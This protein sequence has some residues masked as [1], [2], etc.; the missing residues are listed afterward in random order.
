MSTLT[1]KLAQI[2]NQAP[3]KIAVQIKKGA[4]YVQYTYKEF[5]DHVQ[6][7]AC[8][9]MHLEIKQGDKIIIML[10][11]RPEWG[12]IYFG[13]LMAGAIAVPVDPQSN[14]N[15]LEYFIKDSASKI[16]F[17]S[18][19]LLSALKDV[20]TSM[21]AKI[22]VL[23]EM[24]KDVN[25]KTLPFAKF[26]TCPKINTVWPKIQSNHLASI[27]YTSGTTGKPKGVQLTHA[28]FYANFSS[29]EKLKFLSTMPIAPQNAKF[30]TN[31][32]VPEGDILSKEY[33]EYC[34]LKISSSGAKAEV[35]NR[36]LRCDGHRHNVLSILPLHHSFPFMVTL[37][38]PLFTQNKITYLISLKREEILTCMREAG[39]TVL[40]GVPQF[41]VLLSKAINQAIKTTPFFLRWPLYGLIEIGWLLRK[42]S[43]INLNKYFLYK[44]HKLFGKKL[45]FLVCGG[46]KLNLDVEIFFNKLGFSLMQGYGLTETAPVVTFNPGVLRKLGSVGK[47]IPDVEVK[48]INQDSYGIG[49]IIIKGA[50]VMQGYYNKPEETAQVIKNGW[51]YSGDLGYLDPDGFL[52]IT[53][54]KKELI[55]LSSGKNITPEQVET[56]YQQSLFIK[57]LC[58]VASSEDKIMAV[59]VP[60]FDHLRKVGVIDAYTMIK[61]DLEILSK[62][63]PEYKRIMGF[64]ITKEDLPRTRLGKLKRHVIQAEYADE[65]KQGKQTAYQEQ[66]VSTDDLQII[67]TPVFKQIVEV[68]QQEKQVQQPISL[69]DHLGIDLGFDSLNRVELIA[70]LEKKFNLRITES[71]MANVF[72]VKELVAAVNDLLKQQKPG[73]KPVEIKA[74]ETLWRDLLNTDPEKNITDKINL[75]P[76]ILDK[77]ATVMFCGGLKMIAKLAW[78]IEVEGAEN[79]PKDT[80]FVLCPNHNSY[81][82]AFLMAA[83]LPNSVE[84]RN[85]FLGYNV[86]VDVPIIRDLVKIGRIIPIDPGVKLVEA[87]QA[88]GYVLRHGKVICI[89]PEGG[90]STDGEVKTFK[91]G[92]GILAKELNVPLIP[93]YIDGLFTALPRGRIFPRFNKV[94]IIFGK[95]C[96]S[97]QLQKQGQALGETDDYAAIT[98]AIQQQVIN[99]M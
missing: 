23:D 60:D 62:D 28:N 69:N 68:I 2:V 13:I 71:L 27:L 10:E 46:A 35:K 65:L 50:N 98:R 3:D 72:T 76:D 83:A 51:F 29:I 36:I 12:F 4:E 14:K 75:F 61:T 33:R 16:I 31:D 25:Q 32:F 6:S 73:I 78:R 39:I 1:E 94:K 9:L 57:E 11:N 5:Y 17:I 26:F 85:F 67:A 40:S 74:K 99:L 38:L 59:I 97:E 8:S 30:G 82:D 41:F 58:V 21:V 37:V 93:V 22:I 45:K 20:D 54:R 80:V 92:V 43:K 19:Q 48:I 96:T 34:A 42:F 66:E 79:L 52:F 77:F 87:L 70:S 24:P 55:V 18:N 86:F 90:R 84:I 47:A 64:V 95:P 7:V 49:E 56:H 44:V 15:D 53:G 81:L 89:F 63:Y 88:C 91:K